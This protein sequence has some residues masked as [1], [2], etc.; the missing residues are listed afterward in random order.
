MGTN[1]RVFFVY[2]PLESLWISVFKGHFL[3]QFV[4]IFNLYIHFFFI[5]CFA[6]SELFLTSLT[7]PRVS[8]KL[9]HKHSFALVSTAKVLFLQQKENTAVHFIFLRRLASR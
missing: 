2:T 1:S 8:S 9:G 3:L 7:R 5:F 4:R 6:A